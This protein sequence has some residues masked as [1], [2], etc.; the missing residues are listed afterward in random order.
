MTST[1]ASKN[2]EEFR[3]VALSHVNVTVPANVEAAA[4]E[5]YGTVLG[6]EQ[7]PKPPGYKTK[8]GSVV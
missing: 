3:V 2:A 6:L 5:F 1:N 8:H 7:I 4:K